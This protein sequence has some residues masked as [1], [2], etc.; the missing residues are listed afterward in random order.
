MGKAVGVLGGVV[1]AIA[2]VVGLILAIICG[3]IIPE[4]YV[5]VVY[6]MK[7]GVEDNLLTQGW[8]WVSPMKRVQKFTI[9]NEQI[10]LSQDSRDGSE[11]DDSFQVATADNANIRISFQMS[12]RFKVDQVVET[13]K[14]F[15]GMDGQDIIDQRVRAVLKS[16]VSEVTT[17]FTMMDIYSGNRSQINGELTTYL[18]EELGREYGIEVIDATIIDVHPDAQLQKT[19]DERVTAMQKAQQAQAEQETIRIQNETAIMQAEAEAEQIRIQTEAEAERYRELSAAI[20]PELLQK[21]E[22]DARMQHGWVTVQGGTT[23]VDAT[24]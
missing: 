21:W 20:T 16:K 17:D 11:E 22:M 4:G 13:Y 18:N 23:V 6:S 2:M 5:G 19:I 15:Q 3:T 24:N 10:I 1:L 8:H 14:K 12:Y 7:G 9:G